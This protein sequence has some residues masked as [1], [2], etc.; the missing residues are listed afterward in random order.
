MGASP[1]AAGKSPIAG[2][3]DPTRRSTAVVA[4]R[5]NAIFTSNFKH[6]DHHLLDPGRGSTHSIDPWTAEHGEVG[7]LTK[8]LRR[9]PS[10]EGEHTD[11]KLR[12]S[13]IPASETPPAGTR[14]CPT[15][16]TS[17]DPWIP[18]PPATGAAGVGGGIHGPA[19]SEV[20]KLSGFR[21]IASR[22]TVGER[23]DVQGSSCQRFTHLLV[24]SC[25]P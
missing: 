22:N 17:L 8:M 2:S 6:R 23:G 11:T 3:E 24:L 25:V 16:Y 19:A 7:S 14:T 12:T 4:D 5:F 13:S 9:A 20:G 1:K 18:Q 15:L 21:K 10:P